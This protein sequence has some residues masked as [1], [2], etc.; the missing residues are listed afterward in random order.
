MAYDEEIDFVPLAP[1]GDP[2][3]EPAP[4]RVTPVRLAHLSGAAPW[5]AASALRGPGRPSA[6]LGPGRPRNV[7]AQAGPS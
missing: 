1:P 5:L 3:L 4:A 7:T 2:G 6:F